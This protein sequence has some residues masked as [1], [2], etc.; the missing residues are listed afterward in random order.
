MVKNMF[1]KTVTKPVI[2]AV[3]LSALLPLQIANAADKTIKNFVFFNLDRERIN[4]PSFLNNANVI[5]AQLKYRWSELEP[6]KDQYEFADIK[7]DLAYLTQHN[8]Q[9]FIQLQDISFTESGVN[10]PDYIINEP[11]YNG[12]VAV[13]YQLKQG[14][15]IVG[16][17]G[18]VAR[19]WDKNVATRFYKL[20]DALGAEFDGKITGIN[21]AETAVEFGETG[22]LY[23]DGFTPKIYHQAIL[24]Q[25]AALKAAFPKSVA[26]Q[27]ANFMPGEW[28]PWED[29]GYLTS[30]YEFAAK[31]NI[32]MGGPDIKVY[33]KAQM[34]HSYKFLKQYAGK[35]TS[36]MAVQYGN[37]QIINPKT[38]KQVTVE[39]IYN[40]GRDEAAADYI[41]WST[42]QPFYSKKVLPFIA[43]LK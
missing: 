34:N 3:L 39:E 28:L 38:D 2:L 9:L 16:E 37:Y 26:M 27:Y 24:D 25:M 43:G 29:K 6:N 36:G 35:I 13:Q 1:K 11:K 20:L 22:K 19:R 4:E 32:G 17:D 14:D 8:K 10:V 42:Q 30:L 40:F 41:F 15:V 12:G 23:P 5:G 18:R 31:N 21:L 7:A 33:R